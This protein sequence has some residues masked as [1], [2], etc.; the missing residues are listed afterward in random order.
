MH[1]ILLAVNSGEKHIDNMTQAEL[2]E[3]QCLALTMS[4]EERQAFLSIY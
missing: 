2:L 1:S 4:F 3:A